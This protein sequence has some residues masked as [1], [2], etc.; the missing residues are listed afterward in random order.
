MK[1]EITKIFNIY[2]YKMIIIIILIYFWKWIFIIKCTRDYRHKGLAWLAGGRMTISLS[3]VIS[4]C[5]RLTSCL[6]QED[7]MEDQGQKKRKKSPAGSRAIN[8]PNC[9]ARKGHLGKQVFLPVPLSLS[10]PSTL[11]CTVNQKHKF[12]V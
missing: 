10:H 11:Y 2:P 8:W 1:F 6:F 9:I 5:V 7:S 3:S 12:L 4:G